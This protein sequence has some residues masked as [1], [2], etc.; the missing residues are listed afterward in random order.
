MVDTFYRRKGKFRG[1]GHLPL[2]SKQKVRIWKIQV[3]IATEGLDC[4]ISID[5]RK[6]QSHPEA[7][8]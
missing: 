2:E 5:D 1:C 3:P 7:E 4:K 6:K 8:K